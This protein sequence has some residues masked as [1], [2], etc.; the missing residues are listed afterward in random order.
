VLKLTK[1]YLCIPIA[2][3]LL[4]GWAGVADAAHVQG[5]VVDTKG[6]PVSGVTVSLNRGSKGEAV[7]R[8]ETFLAESDAKG[9]FAAELPAGFWAACINGTHQAVLDP[10]QWGKQLSTVEI[11]PTTLES[12]LDIVVEPATIVE[13]GV[14]DASKVMP[15]PGGPSSR[16]SFVPGVL[17]PDGRF[18]AATL[19]KSDGKGHTFQIAV[20]QSSDIR[21]TYV[22]AGLE[23]IDKKDAHLNPGQTLDIKA[24]QGAAAT[25]IEYSIQPSS[26]ALANGR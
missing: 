4:V 25:K 17:A 19:V 5:R 15:V 23:L 2:S 26:E 11:A 1:P 22:A 10:C 12:R 16:N 20:P 3:A 13:I 6:K 18:R 9:D 7:S 24:K 21:F 8:M 14:L